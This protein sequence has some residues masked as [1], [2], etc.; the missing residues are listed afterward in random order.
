M[1]YPAIHRFSAY[2]AGAE[3][4]PRAEAIADRVLTLPLHPK[5]EDETVEEVCTALLEGT[6]SLPEGP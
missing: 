5:L 1:H 2:R 6:A 3:Q 4:L